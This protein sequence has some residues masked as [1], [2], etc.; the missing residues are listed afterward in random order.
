M[1][2]KHFLLF[3][4]GS[5]A[6][7]CFRGCSS[8]YFRTDY[9][10]ANSLIHSTAN[11][12]SKLFLKAHLKNGGIFI[13]RDT[14][15]A[16]VIGNRVTGNGI[17]Y[18]FNRNVIHEG[19][20]SISL[21]S[22]AI[23]ETNSKIKEPEQMRV[24]AL[25]LMVAVDVIVGIICITNP[26]ACFGSCPTFYID[27]KDNFH[28][29]DAEGFSDAI[30]PSMEYTDIDALNNKK[31]T[32]TLFAITMKNEALET[33]C[34]N[35]V[36]LLAC[37]RKESQRV[38]QS[39]SGDFFQCENHYPLTMATGDEGNITGLLLSNNKQE[40]FS[41]SDGASMTSK[42][43]I[44]LAFD[45][46]KN[47]DNLGLLINFRQTLMTTYLI[48]SALGYMGD[49]AGDIF[50]KI[51]TSR[52]VKGKLKEGMR[53]ELGNI[54]V[55]LLDERKNEWELQNG[56]Y[57]TGPIAINSQILPLKNNPGSSSVKL[58]LV[59]NRGLWRIDYLALTNITQKVEATEFAPVSILNKGKL[60]DN[61]LKDI[62][63]PDKYLIS[64]PG[65][66]Y[67]FYFSLPDRNCDYELFLCSRGYYLEWMRENWIKD[68]N[69]VKLKQMIDNPK[70]YLQSEAKNYKTYE[71][72][73]ER[74]FWNS[75]IDTKTFVY[76][77][78]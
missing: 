33:H 44:H 11:L 74:E 8:Y 46:V 10:D 27:E 7:L 21:D 49:E 17:Q 59:M 67:K 19:P 24:A 39:P 28:Y 26:K 13:F 62:H 32:D 72:T 31:L 61:A 34:V 1:K 20:V 4:I 37:P 23:F 12:Q 63:D 16:D 42:E 25:C 2:L 78:N 65:S 15:N 5:I 75:R 66:E 50:A 40:R 9:K 68:K 60:D 64:M 58:K 52:E 22:V 73:M 38:Y 41:L 56:F 30:S 35:D 54:D 70:H 71:T 53:K 14:W 51:E 77:E 47:T 6:L 29:A 3:L 76:Y 55:Y 36:K 48:Y 57:E 69:L 18:D 45:H 43:E